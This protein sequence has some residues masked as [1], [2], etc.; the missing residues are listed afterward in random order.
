MT[1]IDRSLRI[2]KFYPNRNQDGLVLRE[3]RIGNKTIEHYDNRDDRVIYRSVRFDANK[4]PTSKDYNF[5]DNHF[6]T[7]VVTKMT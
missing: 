2:I 3:E 6:G 5:L 4:T 7:V 1:E